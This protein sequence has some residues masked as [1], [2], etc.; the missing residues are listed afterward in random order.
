ML[1]QRWIFIFNEDLG[2]EIGEIV[3]EV[4]ENS[5]GGIMS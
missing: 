2:A 5:K 4:F 3:E 1:E